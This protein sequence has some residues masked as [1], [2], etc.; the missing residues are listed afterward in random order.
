[1]DEIKVVGGG[2]GGLVAAI[3][4]AEMGARVRVYEAHSALGGR[5]RSTPPPFVANDGPHVVYS[6]GPMWAWLKQRRLAAPAWSVPTS[7]AAGFRFRRNGR[8]AALPPAGLIRMVLS[9]VRS[10]PVDQDFLSWASER[11]GPAAARAAA[12]FMG[13]ATFDAD[14]GRL[15]AAFVWERFRRVVQLPPAARYVEG[16]WGALIDRLAARAHELGVAVE[17]S[18]RVDALP[19]PPLIVA[20][21]LWAART[22]LGDD[23]L[24]WES[25][26]T[27][28]L[29]VAFQARR[30]DP[31]IISDLDEAGWVERFS[32]PDPTLSPAGHSL[33]QAQLPLRPGEPGSQARQRLAYLLDVGFVGWRDRVAWQRSSVARG[34]T[35]AL[36]L[37]GLTWRD[38]PRVDRGDGVYLVGD[39]VAAPGLLSEVSFNSAVQAATSAANL[40][41]TARAR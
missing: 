12:N 6:D 17:T 8:M 16:G 9:K 13:V 24:H 28:L 37:P 32:A 15:S 1:M 21:S 31:F 2:L 38:R 40:L 26:H 7:A 41:A 39:M 14:P 5:G 20:T 23:S 35:G 22:L 36:D 10:A 19:D 25:G 30:G 11:Y 3:T 29:D 4:A 27:A 34:R 33:V 18:S